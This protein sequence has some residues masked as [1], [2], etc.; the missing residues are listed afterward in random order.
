MSTFS[1]NLKKLRKE[2]KFTQEELAK[3]LNITKSRINMYERGEREPKFEMLEII[4]DYFNV[5]MN[6]LLGK[7]DIRNSSFFEGIAKNKEKL[8]KESI[9][10]SPYNFYA[11]SEEQDVIIAYRSA[12]EI[13]KTIVRRTL[14]LDINSDTKKTF[15]VAA[16]GNENVQINEDKAKQL[17]IDSEKAPDLADSDFL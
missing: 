9:P 8:S 11:S 1:E 2:K 4:A 15:R 16:R 5:D 14:K 13:D 17:S 6:F 7:T 10:S 3:A 12:D